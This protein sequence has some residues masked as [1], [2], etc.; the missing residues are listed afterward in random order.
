MHPFLGTSTA[1]RPGRHPLLTVIDYSWRVAA[2]DGTVVTAWLL[3][4][5]GLRGP[6]PRTAPP[7]GGLRGP[8]RPSGVVRDW[9]QAPM[10]FPARGPWPAALAGAE[11]SAQRSFST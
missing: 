2:T 5:G 11:V 10:M 3:Q 6:A 4:S 8:A 9:D 7:V 1:T